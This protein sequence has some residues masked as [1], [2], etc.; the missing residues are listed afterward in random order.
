M[1]AFAYKLSFRA[2]Q[3]A[4]SDRQQSA[5]I[6][7]QPPSLADGKK[8]ENMT[9]RIAEIDSTPTA[10][11]VYA[12]VFKRPWSTPEWDPRFL[13]TSKNLIEILLAHFERVVMRLEL[14][15]IVKIQG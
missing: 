5:K 9:I 4:D 2:T 6:G 11:V 12:H 10:A 7:H 15:P 14:R 13:D 3:I 1:T 8:L